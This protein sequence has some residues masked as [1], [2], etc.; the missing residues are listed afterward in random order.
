MTFVKLV[1]YYQISQWFWKFPEFGFGIRSKGVYALKCHSSIK[2]GFLISTQ[3]C[4]WN[5][6]KSPQGRAAQVGKL[7]YL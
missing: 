7:G 4:G 5:F 6:I 3:F 2:S 1:G